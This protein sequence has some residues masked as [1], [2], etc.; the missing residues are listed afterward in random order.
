MP[1]RNPK[2]IMDFM[3]MM[4]GQN[5]QIFVTNMVNEAAKQGNPVM[6]NLANLIKNGETDKIESVVRN[7]AK[8]KGIT[9]FDE[10]FKAFKQMFKL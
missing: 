2:Q 6:Q 8:E 5:P 3:K 10:E 7:V 9:D 1:I 4:K